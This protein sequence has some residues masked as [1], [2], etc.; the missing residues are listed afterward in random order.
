MYLRVAARFV[1]EIVSGEAAGER[2]LQAAKIC[3]HEQAAS[4]CV[5]DVPTTASLA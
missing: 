5:P 2:E 3:L 4:A 1:F